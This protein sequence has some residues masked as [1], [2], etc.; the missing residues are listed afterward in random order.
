MY[1]VDKCTEFQIISISAQPAATFIYERVAMIS[2]TLWFLW[3][4][5][6]FRIIPLVLY[7]I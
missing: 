5:F 3:R 2:A 6:S 7:P 1:F 4:F